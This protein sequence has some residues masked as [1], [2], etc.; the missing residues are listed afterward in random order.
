MTTTNNIVRT[1][2]FNALYAHPGRNLTLL[3]HTAN[4]NKAH[5]DA[6][7]ITNTIK[8]YIQGKNMF[9]NNK[10][11]N[12]N[13]GSN[14]FSKFGMDAQFSAD[15]TMTLATPITLFDG[16]KISVI[17]QAKYLYLREVKKQL[18]RI[19]Q[20][21]TSRLYQFKKR[22]EQK[23]K[24]Q[25]QKEQM[26]YREQLYKEQE[27]REQEQEEQKEQ[28]Q[29]EQEQKEQEQKEQE[30]KEQEQK[31]QEQKEQKA[32][33]S[34]LK[35][36]EIPSINVKFYTLKRLCLEDLNTKAE[37]VC[38]ICL[39][40]PLIKNSLLLLCNHQFCVGCIEQL[41]K[42]KIDASSALWN[43]IKHVKCPC[44]RQN[45]NKIILN[46]TCE[47]AFSE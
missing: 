18:D 29:K 41:S 32:K 10:N 2:D 37:N 24:E 1:E 15:N 20:N 25:K 42:N 45:S 12:K 34:G 19:L 47:W 21:L 27:Q 44:C 26:F 33:I 30:Q 4:K 38:A 16:S 46:S 23:Q 31:E 35:I 9:L 14:N 11:K 5:T 43:N 3:E 22:Q 17:T 6:E 39:E 7:T 13:N 8:L 36:R 40:T 28:E